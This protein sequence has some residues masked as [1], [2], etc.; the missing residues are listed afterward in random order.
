MH[1]PTDYVGNLLNNHIIQAVNRVFA[2]RQSMPKPKR[3]GPA[4]FDRECRDKRSVAIRAGEKDE[5]VKDFAGLMDKSKM[6]KACNQT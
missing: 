4:W 6:Y 2:T 1:M 5:T 3:R